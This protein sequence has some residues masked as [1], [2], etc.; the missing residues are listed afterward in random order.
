MPRPP[1]TLAI[2]GAALALAALPVAAQRPHLDLGGGASFP[3]GTLGDAQDAGWHALVAIGYRP[4]LSGLGFR[5]DGSYHRL[6]SPGTGDT[7]GRDFRALAVTGNVVREG[8]ALAVRPYVLAGAGL[9]R[10]ELEGGEARTHPG[11]TLGA[12]LR[13]HLLAVDA[14]VEARYHA[15]LDA[16]PGGGTGHLVP[17]TLG[18]TF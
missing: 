12:G 10:T 11:A 2:A 15:M 13:F 7:P 6:H 5:L 18:I 1:V 17:L 9:Y 14:F 8:P 3:V 4:P 16:L